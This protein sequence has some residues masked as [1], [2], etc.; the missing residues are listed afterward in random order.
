MSTRHHFLAVAL[1]SIAFGVLAA[2]PA[3]AQL[4]EIE[5]T[6]VFPNLPPFEFPIGLTFANDGQDYLY[7]P[8]WRGKVKVFENIPDVDT[9]YVFLDVELEEPGEFYDIVFHPDYAV[10]GYVYV[11]YVTPNPDRTVIA[12]YTRAGGMPPSVDP[13]S[14]LVLLEIAQPNLTAHNGGKISFG[15][16]GYLYIPLGDGGTPLDAAG[17]AQNPATLLGSVLRIDVDNPSGGLNYGIPPDNPFVGNTDGWREE[18][19][20]YGFRNPYSSSFD[21]LTGDFWLGDVGEVTWEEVN[22]IEAGQNYGW[23]IMEGPECLNG[24]PCDPS[25]YT[26]PFY[27]Y[28]HNGGNATVIA[29]YVY[30]GISIPGLY[31]LYVFADFFNKLWAFDYSDSAN[32][33]VTLLEETGNIVAIGE[34]RD[35]EL[36]IPNFF[37]GQ[38][39]KMTAPVD[40]STQLPE[41]G[42]FVRELPY[43]NPFRYR[44]SIDVFLYE[45]GRLSV[46]I[47]DVL[48]RHVAT[49]FDGELPPRQLKQVVFD[50][51]N[52]P[53]GSYF[54]RVQGANEVL[55]RRVSLVK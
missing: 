6:R 27:A 51:S 11:N 46:K 28:N 50:G 42:L 10:N 34:D 49:L 2:N 13:A 17:N 43:P 7:I 44:T 1:C 41:E 8:E 38:M 31:G 21:R 54:I 36:Y 25:N 47:Y 4:E 55:T 16:D 12:R 20:A 24:A 39:F 40:S 53:A 26:T 52:L 23:P 48:G 30:R 14:R 9:S 37:S 15:P 33:D 5:L 3:H 35:G 18:V 32:I 29:G 22:R 19:W 45:G